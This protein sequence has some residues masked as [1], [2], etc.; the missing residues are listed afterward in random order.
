[1]NRIKIEV[2]EANRISCIEFEAW[3]NQPVMEADIRRFIEA[4]RDNQEKMIK[5]SRCD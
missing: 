1:M 2:D 3:N 5:I 4:F